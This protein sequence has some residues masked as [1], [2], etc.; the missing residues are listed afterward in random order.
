MKSRGNCNI[1]FGST[2]HFPEEMTPVQR[3]RRG[4]ELAVYGGTEVGGGEV[5]SRQR[6]QHAWKPRGRR[7]GSFREHGAW[8]A[9]CSYGSVGQKS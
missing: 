5:Y 8:R 1:G 7:A 4:E 2:K 6:E 9:F 3:P